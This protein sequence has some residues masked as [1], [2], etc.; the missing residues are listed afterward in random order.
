[1]RIATLA[2]ALAAGAVTIASAQA[3]C[4]SRDAAA[5]GKAIDR[6]NTW[7]QLHK[8][9]KDWGRCDSGATADGFT[10]AIMRL[11][12]D[13]KNVET[14]AADMKGDPGYHDFIIAH[15]KGDPAKEDRD[16]LFSRAKTA[17]PKGQD[18][19]CAEIID[20]AS[21]GGG[22][23]KGGDMGLKTPDLLQPLNV[24]SLPSTTPPPAKK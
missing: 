14:L 15:I 9:W 16:A 22:G 7:E 19:F 23:G 18:A 21:G 13:W 17:C 20:V 8:S 2:A 3:P 1:M 4:T 12:V 6:V 11:G 24:P 5:A 10:D